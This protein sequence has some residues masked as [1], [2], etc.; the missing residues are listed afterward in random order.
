MDVSLC[1]YRMLCKIGECAKK[2]LDFG[3][4]DWHRNRVLWGFRRLSLIVLLLS[5]HNG[6]QKNTENLLLNFL[7]ECSLSLQSDPL[8]SP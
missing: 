4:R 6:S 1:N 7:S 3:R 8:P 5:K 2:L